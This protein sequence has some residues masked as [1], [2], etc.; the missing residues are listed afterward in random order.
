VSLLDQL[1]QRFID[2]RLNAPIAEQI[3]VSA[4][5]VG[6][7]AAS[8]AAIIISVSEYRMAHANLREDLRTQAKIIAIN[9][10]AAVSFD[11]PQAAA[12][13]L[14]ALR[15]IPDIRVGRVL[16]ADGSELARFE[17]DPAANGRETLRIQEPVMH[18]GAPIA[19]FELQAS[20]GRVHRKIL[21]HA[22]LV[23]TV[24]A[25]MVLLINQLMWRAIIILS[26]PFRQLI[27]VMREIRRRGDYSLR[28]GLLGK[29]EISAMARNF[30]SVLDVLQL[31]EDA[32]DKEL[33]ERRRAEEQLAYIAHYATRTGLPTRNA[34]NNGLKRESS[35]NAQIAV[36]LLDVDKFKDI[37]DTLGHYVGDA[38]LQG[39]AGRLHATIVASNLD[40]LIYRIGGDEFAVVIGGGCDEAAAEALGEQIIDAMASPQHLYGKS[41]FASA[42]IGLAIFPQHAEDLHGL[43]RH[44]DVALYAAKGRGRKRLCVFDPNMNARAADRL[45]MEVELRKAVVE[46]QLFLVYEPQIDVRSNRLIAAEALVRWDH[47]TRG[48]VSPSDFIT[49]AEE[50]GL[51]LPL[52][53]WVLERACAETKAALDEG[54]CAADFKIGVNLSPRQ[55]ADPKLV[56]AIARII[57]KSGLPPSNL[58]FE[59]TESSVIENIDVVIERMHA[60]RALG[61]SFAMDDF[62]VGATSLS[63]LKR[64]PLSK[65]KIDR[66]FVKDL[67]HDEEDAA[68]ATAIIAMAHRL[69]KPVLA[70][71]IEREEQLSFLREHSCDMAQ[72][73]MI[74]RGASLRE[75]LQHTRPPS[76]Y[77]A[78]LRFPDPLM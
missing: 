59:I 19:Q 76:V 3:T 30:D 34:V 32:L 38:L 21:S 73:Y 63:Y 75:L 40:A 20:Y 74:G 45:Q 35:R 5:L 31:R 11:D 69:K 9:L 48:L 44:A 4:T 17:S 23:V 67:P 72:G 68:I 39:I 66:S 61:V 2:W 42:S 14:T 28:S 22:L 54:L 33:M 52:G 58:E 26:R 47:P 53:E 18:V 50:T 29:N 46:N 37:N 25:L 1:Q 43:V 12:E 6:V 65:V 10:E 60:L 8:V 56:D 15:A 71:G 64:L 7:V 62:G 41:V 51:I 24:M 78:Q 49:V 77:D 36:M 16:R 27:E 57:E 13:I 70:E 55:L